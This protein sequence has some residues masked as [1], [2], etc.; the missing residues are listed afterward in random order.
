MHNRMFKL[1]SVALALGLGVSAQ[2]GFINGG[3]ETGDFT[4]WTLEHG[5]NGGANNF[6]PSAGTV[7][8]IVVTPAYVDPY[9]PY[10][11]VINET[12]TARIN[13]FANGNEATRISQTGI[14]LAGETDVFINWAAVMEDPGHPSGQ[15]PFF[16]IVVN[17]NGVL[18]GSESHS[19]GVG[20]GWTAGP[21]F[22][23][24]NGS[25]VFYKSGQFHLSGLNAGD[26]VQVVM[27]VLDCSQTGH[28]GWA[29]LDGIGTVA[30]PPVGA[31]DG[32]STALLL[33]P[34]LLGLLA[35]RRKK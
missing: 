23:G 11:G 18:A 1:A 10:D 14:M 28:S 24:P 21:A 2:A 32:G 12:R 3:F 26:S 9:S 5:F 30:Q 33:A 25:T 20:V 13:D 8:A 35:L 17:V 31:P 15:D 34:A 16:S 4:G 22:G 27:T 7:D 6:V 29:Y 19:A